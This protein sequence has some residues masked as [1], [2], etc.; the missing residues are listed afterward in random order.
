MDLHG[1]VGLLLDL[2]PVE[3]LGAGDEGAVVGRLG[4]QGIL[5]PGLERDG[6]PDLVLLRVVGV[7]PAVL[8]PILAV[9][10]QR[11][12]RD[13]RVEPEVEVLADLRGGGVGRRRE[14]R[15]A[16]APRSE[17]VSATGS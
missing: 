9:T 1:G 14:V 7:G 17:R 4:G 11:D 5:G 2:A 15:A 6:L 12:V 16:S 10:L 3:E 8:D 13:P